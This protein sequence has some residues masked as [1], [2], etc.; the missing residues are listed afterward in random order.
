MWK[1]IGIDINHPR[2]LHRNTSHNGLMTLIYIVYSARR[3]RR[4]PKRKRRQ[5]V[6]HNIIIYF[7]F[8]E[9]L[10]PYNLYRRS[11]RIRA[12]NIPIIPTEAN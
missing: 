12:N 11:R 2:Y 6:D 4:P 1:K 5:T 3:T 9:C 10:K 8:C 7:F